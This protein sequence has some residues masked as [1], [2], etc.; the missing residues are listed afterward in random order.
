MLD[1]VKPFNNKSDQLLLNIPIRQ[2]KAYS[3]TKTRFVKP[4]YRSNTSRHRGGIAR[5]T[6]LLQIN[7]PLPVLCTLSENASN[8]VFLF[9]L[10]FLRADNHISPWTTRNQKN[11]KGKKGR[12]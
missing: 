4:E 5:G 9:P 12:E 7:H 8:A 2:D 3:G 1:K 11:D 6:M 10:P